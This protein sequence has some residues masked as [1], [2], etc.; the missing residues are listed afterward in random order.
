VIGL[1]LLHLLEGSKGDLFATVP[2]VGVP[3]PCRGV[4]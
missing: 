1:E 4:E 2:D 3:E